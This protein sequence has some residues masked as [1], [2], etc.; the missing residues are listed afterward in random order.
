MGGWTYGCMH[1]WVDRL[2]GGQ[3]GCWVVGGWVDGRER[4][5]DETVVANL[6][7]KRS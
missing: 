1:K 5:V 6:E 2:V 7:L 3:M 4:G